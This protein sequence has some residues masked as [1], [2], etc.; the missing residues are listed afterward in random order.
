MRVLVTGCAGFIGSQIV[1]QCLASDMDVVGIDSI[2]DYYDVD[3]KRS[4]L[5][6][7]L[8]HP[9]YNFVHADIL[10]TD[11]SSLFDGVSV[12]FHQAGQ[13]GVRDSWS[14][15]DTYLRLNVLVTQRLLE[16]ARSAKLDR[17]VYAS[18]SSLYGN[19]PAYP[20]HETDLPAP[21]SPYGVTKL[22]GEH[23]CGVYGRNF[24]VP[25][26]SL[27]YFTVYGPRQ[28]PDMATHRLIEA[29]ATGRSFPMFGDGS[30][31]RDFTF[32]GD[33]VSANLA[34]VSAPLDPGSVMNIAG[35]ASAT[36]KELIDLVGEASGRSVILEFHPDAAGDVERTG[37]DIRRASDLIGWR[38]AV[39]LAD[40]IRQQVAWH[41]ERRL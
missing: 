1:E 27:R 6:R 39:S 15:F 7:A 31:I 22:A 12:V 19:A 25:T 21:Q 35:G 36:M 24:G 41:R 26:V 8:A 20:T 30:K 10:E 34:A 2:T 11:L 37:G 14:G 32:V 38:P 9:R 33:V 23:L 28:R 29:C 3:Q 40:G 5:T 18:S 4:N 17:F 16:A 13:P